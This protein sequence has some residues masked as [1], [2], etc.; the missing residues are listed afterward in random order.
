[1]HRTCGRAQ[2]RRFERFVDVG[3]SG[4]RLGL[5]SGRLYPCGGGRHRLAIPQT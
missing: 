3:V 1:M 2:V 5:D 4:G